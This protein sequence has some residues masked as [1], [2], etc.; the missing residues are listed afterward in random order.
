MTTEHPWIKSYPPGVRWNARLPV[1]PIHGVLEDAAATWP[2]HAAIDFM[3]RRISYS[4]LHDLVRRAAKGFQSLGVGPGVHVGLYLANS[5]HYAIAFYGILVAGGVVVNY[6]PLD[7]DKVL[8]HKVGDSE[9]DILVT[10]DLA[11]L[12]PKMARLLDCTRLKTLV[13]GSLGDYSAQPEAVRFG[14]KKAGELAEMASDSRHLSFE[15]L[16]DNDGAPERHPFGDPRTTLAVLQYTGGT[17]GAPKGAMLSHA[18]ITAACSMFCE[19][20]R[21]EQP[22]VGFGTERLLAVLPLFHIYALLMNL[23]I[24]TRLGAE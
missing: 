11:V 7:A 21:G 14:L 8:E 12:Y 23:V 10:L 22:V 9:T 18:N 4:E 24:A 6:S 16:L 19:T 1:G 2:D 5:P 20:V 13:V 15:R 3:G 17:T